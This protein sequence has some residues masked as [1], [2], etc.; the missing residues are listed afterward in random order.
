MARESKSFSL[1]GFDIKVLLGNNKENVKLIISAI[2]GIMVTQGL[3]EAGIAA[4]ITKN[5]IDA[6][7][8]YV[9]KVKLK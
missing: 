8:F 3:V 9:S 6:L 5:V 4:F 1:E 7:D 2:V